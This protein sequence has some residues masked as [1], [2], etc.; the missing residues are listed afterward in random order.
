MPAVVVGAV[1]GR[2]V[3]I[4]VASLISTSVNPG[5]YSLLGAAAMLGGFTRLALPVSVMLV[6]MTGDATYLV[7]IMYC[8]I[9]GK[10]V[11]DMIEKPLYPQ[12]MA[13]EKI[14]NLGDVLNPKIAPLT[15]GT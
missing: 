10:S 2:I 15:A 5:V 7:P 12:H 8:A 6:E 9:V 11:S 1:Y 13:I 3:G 14:P 4:V